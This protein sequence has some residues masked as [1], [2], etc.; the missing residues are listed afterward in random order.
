MA[1]YSQREKSGWICNIASG[2]S[3]PSRWTVARDTLMTTSWCSDTKRICCQVLCFLC[4]SHTNIELLLWKDVLNSM[5][6]N[7]RILCF[8]VLS[9]TH[10]FQFGC[11]FLELVRGGIRSGHDLLIDISLFQCYSFVGILKWRCFDPVLMPNLTL[12]D[13]LKSIFPH[14]FFLLIKESGQD[15]KMCI[16]QS[17]SMSFWRWLSNLIFEC[18]NTILNEIDF[19]IWN[20]WIF[21]S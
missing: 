13:G 5:E 4:Q 18:I 3:H 9:S 14:I 8:F 7:L 20:P 1:F 21:Q 12:E 6:V 10:L 2:T 19:D 16:T 11:F 15:I 17:K